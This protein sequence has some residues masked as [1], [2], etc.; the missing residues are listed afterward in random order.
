[1][2]APY[3]DPNPEPGDLL[4]GLEQPPVWPWFFDAQPT[5]AEDITPLRSL[6]PAH[7]PRATLS[8]RRGDGR[9]APTPR[10]VVGYIDPAISEQVGSHH[11]VA[12]NRRVVRSS[13]LH[14]LAVTFWTAVILLCIIGWALAGLALGYVVVRWLVAVL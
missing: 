13:W 4:R 2:T 7:Q 12:V 3:R 5:F 10:R 1:M 6:L 8:Q 14:E 11:S 9:R